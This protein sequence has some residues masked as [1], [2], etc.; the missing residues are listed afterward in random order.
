M[1]G[2]PADGAPHPPGAIHIPPDALPLR[3]LAGT[4]GLF[5]FIFTTNGGSRNSCCLNLNLITM[6]SRN[7]GPIFCSYFA[8]KVGPF[9]I[10]VSSKGVDYVLTKDNFRE[11][12]TEK[13][14]GSKFRKIEKH[15]S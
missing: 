11:F 2:Q 12:G 6:S 14:E 15:H 4:L 5:R 1:R 9:T 3:Q 8:S 13:G 10:D 7:S